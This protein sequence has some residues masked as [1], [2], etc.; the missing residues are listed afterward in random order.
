MPGRPSAT[1]P[2]ASLRSVAGPLLGG[3]VVFAILV[4]LAF[5]VPAVAT[6]GPKHSGVAG[7]VIDTTCPGPCTPQVTNPGPFMGQA[8]V[9]IRRLRGGRVARVAVDESRFRRSLRP[10]R[11]RL[12]TRID[13][14]CWR[15]DARKVR[16]EKGEFE[17]LLLHV[18]NECLR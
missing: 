2:D 7:R 9:V 12:T 13:G 1:R 10:G 15:H 17:R 14:P 4:L 8:T 11:Y 3:S 18:F 6:A 16:V 5:V